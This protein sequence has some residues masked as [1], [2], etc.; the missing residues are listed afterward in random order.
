[1]PLYTVVE[2][3]FE[4]NDENYY[5]PEHQGGEAIEAYKSELSAYKKAHELNKREAIQQEYGLQ[6]F[7]DVRSLRINEEEILSSHD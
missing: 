5:M 6:R 2:I 4:Y 7:Y 3:G 1:M